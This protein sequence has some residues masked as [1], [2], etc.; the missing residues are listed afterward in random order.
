MILKIYRNG[1]KVNEIKT[2]DRAR[3]YKHIAI[4]LMRKIE[5]TESVTVDYGSIYINRIVRNRNFEDTKYVYT[6]DGVT[7]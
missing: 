6:F 1:E 7:L 5:K 4:A 2:T 3:I